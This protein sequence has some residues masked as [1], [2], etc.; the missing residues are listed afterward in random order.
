[1]GVR[2]FEQGVIDRLA[3]IDEIYKATKLPPK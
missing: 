2:K 3:S 1:M